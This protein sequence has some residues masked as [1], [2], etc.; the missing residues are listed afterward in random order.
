VVFTLLGFSF[1]A[2]LPTLYHASQILAIQ[3]TSV[4]ISSLIGGGLAVT[5]AGIL[6]TEGLAR[7][8]NL[9]DSQ[10]LYPTLGGAFLSV[11]LYLAVYM[12]FALIIYLRKLPGIS[13]IHPIYQ[14]LFLIVVAALVLLYISSQFEERTRR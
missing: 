10:I 3:S 7:R 12:I 8:K 1:I 4:I 11:T 14:L 13:F 6:F 2:Q 9:I 5:G